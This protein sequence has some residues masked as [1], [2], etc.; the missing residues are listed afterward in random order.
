MIFTPFRMTVAWR[1]QRMS[2][3][4]CHSPACR[5]PLLHLAD[6]CAPCAAAKR[7]VT[8]LKRPMSKRH[9]PHDQNKTPHDETTWIARVKLNAIFPV[10]VGP[11][12]KRENIQLIEYS[13]CVFNL[14]QFSEGSC[15]QRNTISKINLNPTRI[16][17]LREFLPA[18][19]IANSR[20]QSAS[21]PLFQAESLGISAM[22][23]FPCRSTGTVIG[24]S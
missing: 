4:C 3:T 2:S 19:S 18:C 15:P 16:F 20:Y 9:G 24:F 11:R 21:Q 7:P 12:K 1:S 6:V 23:S 22:A 17:T 10:S 14:S 13:Q 8:N 5:S